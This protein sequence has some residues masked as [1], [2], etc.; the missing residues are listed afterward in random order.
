MSIKTGHKAYLALQQA[1]VEP[2]TQPQ[3]Q[4]EHDRQDAAWR[5]DA[6]EQFALHDFEAFA[7]GRI[8]AHGVVD[9]QA[10]QIKQSR[11]PG[12]H[13]DDVKRLDPEHPNSPNV[14]ASLPSLFFPSDLSVSAVESL[15]CS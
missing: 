8:V 5:H 7:A 13:E 2:V 14:N 10:R 1:A 4:A 15:L 3:P 6:E 12:D 11:E 9:E